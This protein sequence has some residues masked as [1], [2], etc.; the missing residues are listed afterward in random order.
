MKM[1]EL[2]SKDNLFTAFN[3]IEKIKKEK[4]ERKVKPVIRVEEMIKAIR[5]HYNLNAPMLANNLGVN[6][7]SIYKWENG[8]RPSIN[9]YNKIK[10]LYEEITREDKT[11]TLEQPE[12][13]NKEVV[14]DITAGIPF[15]SLTIADSGKKTFV[16]INKINEI[17]L[18]SI[19]DSISIYTDSGCTSVRETPAEILELIRKKLKENEKN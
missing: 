1:T 6:V 15:I 16:N 3:N 13:A 18:F 17:G 2:Y 9:S 4:Q 8:G 12:T 5:E 11:E 14:E 19:S 10:E 7:Q